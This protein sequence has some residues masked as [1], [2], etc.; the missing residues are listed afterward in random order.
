[1]SFDPAGSRLDSILVMTNHVPRLAS[2]DAYRELDSSAY[3]PGDMYTQQVLVAGMRVVPMDPGNY[4]SLK[5][6]C[7]LDEETS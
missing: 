7:Q 6:H 5:S 4:A 1:M 2:W 3:R